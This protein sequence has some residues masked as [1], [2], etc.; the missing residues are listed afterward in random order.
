MISLTLSLALT[1]CK[2]SLE[3]TRGGAGIEV[4]CNLLDTSTTTPETVLQAIELH[5]GRQGISIGA[6]YTTNHTPD[7][8]CRL[9]AEQMA[10]V[11][12]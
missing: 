3:C 1:F 9:A 7:A 6:A 12:A 10:L 5:A 11:S 8:L 4:A 2:A